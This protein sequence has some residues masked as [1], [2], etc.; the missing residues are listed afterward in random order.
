M[1]TNA[2]PLRILP[3]GGLGEIGM[4]CMLV[5]CYDRYILADA[6][7]MFPDFSDLGMQKILPDTSFLH[8]W[9]DKIEALVITHGHEDHIGA[10]P[11]VVPALD[12]STPIFVSSFVKRL[13][14]KRLTEYSL[15]DETRF[16]TFEM[17]KPF[18]AGPFQVE[19]VRVTH[20][21][22]DCCGL[23]MRSDH[24]TIVHTGDWKID[25]TP[26]DG[27]QFDRTTFE[28]LRESFI[29]RFL[30]PLTR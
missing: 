28:K 14:Q 11:W 24:G 5:G 21:I 23:I 6:G 3:I 25:E 30:M 9:R 27:L 7:L 10:M 15:F 22:P 17:N 19:P 26:V 12:P 8:Q 20:S 18:Q 1:D 16:K 4:N 29:P 2:A 13:V